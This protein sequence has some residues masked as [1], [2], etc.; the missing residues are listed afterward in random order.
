[1]PCRQGCFR[2]V[3][4]IDPAITGLYVHYAYRPPERGEPKLPLVVLL[5]GF[6]QEAAD[7]SAAVMEDMARAG[8]FVCAVG[9]RGRDSASGVPDCSGRELHDV[10][11]AV[12][13]IERRFSG[14]LKPGVRCAVGYSGG[15][16]N[17]LGLAAKFP[18]SFAVLVS[19]FGISD[20][21]WDAARSWWVSHPERRPA[22][23]RWI[24][25][26]P[27]QNPGAYLA[28]AHALGAVRNF[29]GSRI[30][31]FHDAE[32]PSVPAWHSQHVADL[33]QAAG[34]SRVELRL[35]DPSSRERWH[36]GLPEIGAPARASRDVWSRCLHGE[37][38][39]P[40]SFPARGRVL[41]QGYLVA[42]DF[43]VWL[44]SGQTHAAWLQYDLQSS[45]FE[46]RSLTG[47]CTARITVG[48]K[49]IEKE[50]VACSGQETNIWTL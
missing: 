9:M 32:D 40:P 34:C 5:H 27:Q 48:S 33:A 39:S 18:D 41:V 15:G 2:Y 23:E 24:G 47:P 36:H 22:L 21:G 14:F 42:R 46:L 20:Y 45:Q 10:L 37:A 29:A 35:S 7:F 50:L 4:S 25:G 31:L 19:H 12:V 30:L 17:V 1:M 6:V 49:T 28:R 38:F 43:S 11:D 16:G 3:S 13:C 26:S 8:L 44:D